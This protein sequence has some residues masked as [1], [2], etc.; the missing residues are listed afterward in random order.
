M[1][2]QM[3]GDKCFKSVECNVLP[4]TEL[5]QCPCSDIDQIMTEENKHYKHN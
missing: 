3:R 1:K 2:K 5:Y 4:L